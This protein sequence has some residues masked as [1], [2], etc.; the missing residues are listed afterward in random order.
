MTVI[1]AH[2]STF[3]YSNL[4]FM[5]RIIVLSAT[6]VL[7]AAAFSQITGKSKDTIYKNFITPPNSAKP[8]VWWNWMNGNITWRHNLYE[9]APLLFKK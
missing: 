4:S 2:H 3:A 9:F 6:L 1:V 7:N 8:H 5:K